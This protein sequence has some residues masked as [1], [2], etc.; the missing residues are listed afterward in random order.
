MSTP[1]ASPIAPP[2]QPVGV[3]PSGANEPNLKGLIIGGLVAVLA[4]SA[5][6][7]FGIFGGDRKPSTANNPDATEQIT[8][9]ETP[10][11]EVLPT[12]PDGTQAETSAPTNTPPI[13]TAPIY[14]QATATSEAWVSIIADNN[15]TPVFEGTLQPGDTQVWE[16]QEKLSVYSGDA[17]ALK[18]SA[19][20]A[21]AVVMG[22]PGQ[23][24]EKIF[25][26]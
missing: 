25:P 12:L 20:G 23:P 24:E 6:I 21:E 4:V 9:S 22:Q 19:N 18:L 17:G 7:L 3:E 2:F 16:A 26:Q 11:T 15:P 10:E 1:A 14:V 8:D 5:I 13:S